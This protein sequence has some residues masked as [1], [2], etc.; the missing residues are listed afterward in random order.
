[1]GLG[2]AGDLG[3]LLQRTGPFPV[4]F[5]QDRGDRSSSAPP[6]ESRSAAS[7]APRR[8]RFDR[9]VD[10]VD[11]APPPRASRPPSSRSRKSPASAR[12]ERSGRRPTTNA[13]SGEA[14]SSI[15]LP[16]RCRNPAD[17]PSNAARNSIVSARVSAPT[18]RPT[19]RR[20]AL[21]PNR[22]TESVSRPAVAV[23][24]SIRR[25]NRPPRKSV[26]RCGASRNDIALRVGGVSTHD[27]V[28]RGRPRPRPADGAS[29]SPCTR[30]SHRACPPSAG[31]SG[32]SACGRAGRGRGE[33]LDQL[34]ERPLRIELQ[35]IHRA[36]AADADRGAASRQRGADAMPWPGV[37]RD[38]T[39]SRI[40]RRA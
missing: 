23:G 29:P 25:T 39:V 9:L 13:H 14:R 22:A 4:R 5:P 18:R 11:H 21:A 30:G 3:R 24:H 7:A 2:E 19:V 34:V 33:S 37:G 8:Q 6:A 32:S 36:P 17:M 16:A 1:M 40:V 31:S 26:R 20:T 12:L 35:R 10:P 15:T 38:R 27:E 28:V